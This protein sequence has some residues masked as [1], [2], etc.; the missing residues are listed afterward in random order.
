PVGED[1]RRHNAYAGVL[2]ELGELGDSQPRIVGDVADSDEHHRRLCKLRLKVDL[3]PERCVAKLPGSDEQGFG[4]RTATVD[5][6]D[7]LAAKVF[8]LELVAGCR[9]VLDAAPTPLDAIIPIGQEK[10]DRIF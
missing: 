3:R 2:D 10:P 9:D 7:E 6:Q 8:R 1:S 5:L 4:L